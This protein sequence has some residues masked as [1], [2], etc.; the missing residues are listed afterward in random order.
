MIN[1][2][3]EGQVKQS[4][5]MQDFAIDVVNHLLPRTFKRDIN[6]FIKFKKGLDNLGTC[7]R[8]DSGHIDIEINSGTV[9][10]AE[11]IAETLAH[12]LVHAKQFIR[13]ELNGSLTRWKKQQIEYG[14]RGGCK[15]PYARQP[16][17]REAFKLE[18]KLTNLYW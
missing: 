17:E 2:F 6:I 10:P 7:T 13:G 9:L 15:I 18:I 12:E 3:F 11:F 1:L 16:W 5:K 8:N 14:P 4:A